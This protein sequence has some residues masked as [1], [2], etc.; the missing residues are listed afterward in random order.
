MLF[1]ECYGCSEEGKQG[2]I[3]LWREDSKVVAYFVDEQRDRQSE[4]TPLPSPLTL[5]L[6][7]LSP[8]T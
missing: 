1:G 3:M 2:G 7:L 4:K 8:L 5:P 6:S